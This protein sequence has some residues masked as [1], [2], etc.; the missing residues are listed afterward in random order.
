MKK[1]LFSILIV[2]TATVANA[3]KSEVAEAKK[4]WGIFSITGGKGAFD[5]TMASLT[6]V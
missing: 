1:L 2:G 3:Q 6:M 5:K 4:K